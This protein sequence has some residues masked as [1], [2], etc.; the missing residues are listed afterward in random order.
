MFKKGDFVVYGHSGV[1]EV[2]SIGNMNSPGIPKDKL[3]YTLLPCYTK[4]S[5]IFTPIDNDKV[6]IRRVLTKEEATTLVDEI[7]YI[8]I[9]DITNEKKREFEY[10]EAFRKCD[11]RELVKIIKTIY[12]REE[13]R[14]AE[15][16]K[17][18]ASDEKYFSMAEDSLYG[19]LAISFDLDRDNVKKFVTDKVAEL[20]E[21][22]QE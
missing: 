6:I 15:G 13:S 17:M 20:V 9:L 18:T 22:K 2:D 3:Y 21:S 1:C 10:K 12:L 14:L 4:G 5:K 7:K 16:K 19:E 11:C 8:D